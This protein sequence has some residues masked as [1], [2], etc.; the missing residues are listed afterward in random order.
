MHQCHDR[1]GKLANP[2]EDPSQPKRRTLVV[3]GAQLGAGQKLVEIRTGTEVLPR[4]AQYQHS[5]FLIELGAFQFPM[6]SVNRGLV[7]SVPLLRTVESK[8]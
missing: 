8:S 7:E 6:Q 4:T 1:L 5:H 3:L 2:E